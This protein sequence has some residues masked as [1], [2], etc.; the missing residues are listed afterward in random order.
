MDNM[1]VA[2]QYEMR[3]RR[4]VRNGQLKRLGVALLGAALVIGAAMLQ[5]YVSAGYNLGCEGREG[6]TEWCRYNP[7]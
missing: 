7:P 1:C 6:A 2:R 3:R 5:R 4:L